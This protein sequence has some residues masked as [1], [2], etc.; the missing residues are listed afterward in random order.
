MLLK[1]KTKWKNSAFYTSPSN[2]EEAQKAWAEEK[3]RGEKLKKV[4]EINHFY[5]HWIGFDV[6]H[7]DGKT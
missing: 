5:N 1:W 6:S 3:M 4:S 7:S 2:S